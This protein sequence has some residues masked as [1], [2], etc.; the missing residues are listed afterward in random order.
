VP[1]DIIEVLCDVNREVYRNKKKA[2]SDYL[3]KGKTF[4]GKSLTVCVKLLSETSFYG[5][6]FITAWESGS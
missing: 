3:V 6:D 4:S 2:R 1:Q 5:S